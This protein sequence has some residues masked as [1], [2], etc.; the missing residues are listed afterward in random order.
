MLKACTLTGVDEKTS[1]DWIRSVSAIHPFAEFAILYSMTP[2]DKDDRYPTR[3]FIERFADAMEGTG[4]RTALHICGRAV[5]AFVAGDEDVR[6]LAARFGRVQINF[7]AA[8]SPFTVEDLA[9]AI[10]S[11][12][13]PVITQHFPSNAVVS[14]FVTAPNH[15]VLFDASGGN[16][17]RG[18]GWPDRVAGK[19][20]GYAGGFGPDTIKVDTMGAELHAHGEDYWI[21]MESRIRSDGW[22]DE[23]KCLT[24]LELVAPWTKVP[25]PTEVSVL[26]YDADGLLNGVLSFGA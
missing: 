10:A 18:E 22:L 19:Y 21:D 23:E 3:E 5:A 7:N 26:Q 24:V 25:A 14:A 2:D 4:V 17:R 16:G 9:L 1:F 15:H 11:V 8:R 20:I 6:A 13:H 12:D